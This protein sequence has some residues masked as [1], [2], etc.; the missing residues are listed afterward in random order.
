M[1]DHEMPP[2]L[3]QLGTK[4][5]LAGV[6]EKLRRN[7]E[8]QIELGRLLAK[9]RR[10]NYLAYVAEGFTDQQALELCQK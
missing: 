3:V 2:Q 9:V 5:E 1:N 8:N 10:A 7:L 6:I 4:D